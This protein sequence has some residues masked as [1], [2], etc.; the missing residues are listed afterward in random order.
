[1]DHPDHFDERNT[2]RAMLGLPSEPV[3]LDIKPPDRLT[4]GERRRLEARLEELDRAPVND[5]VPPPLP[6][7]VPWWQW[8]RR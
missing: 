3:F 1:M 7:P 6:S 5:Y 4:P 2:L 8:W